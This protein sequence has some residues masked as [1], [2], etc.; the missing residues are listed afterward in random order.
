MP[1]SVGRLNASALLRHSPSLAAF[2]TNIAGS[3]FRYTQLWA[4]RFVLEA[5]RRSLLR[6]LL[7]SRLFASQVT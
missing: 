6:L 7:L 1:Q 2:I 3:D 4:E 5:Q